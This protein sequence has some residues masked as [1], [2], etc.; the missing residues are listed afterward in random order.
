ML[1]LLPTIL[2]EESVEGNYQF[3]ED[4]LR[5]IR[6][7]ADEFEKF[8]EQKKSMLV[9]LDGP[10]GVGKSFIVKFL[11][12]MIGEEHIQICAPTNKACHVLRSSFES[13]GNTITC[14]RYFNGTNIYDTDG[15]QLWKFTLPPKTKQ[16]TIIIIDETSMIERKVYDQFVKLMDSRKIFLITLGDVCQLP[17]VDES[18]MI[19]KFYEKYSINFTLTQNIRNTNVDYNEMLGKIREFIISKRYD[20]KSY[21]IVRMLKKYIQ[22][23]SIQYGKFDLSCIPEEVIDRYIEDI[24]VHHKKICLLAYRTNDGKRNTVNELNMMIRKKLYPRSTNRYEVGEKILFTSYFVKDV[25]Y[26]ILEDNSR[27]TEQQRYYTSDADEIIKVSLGKEKF[28]DREFIIYRLYLKSFTRLNDPNVVYNNKLFICMIHHSE[29]KNFNQYSKT[30]RDG[31][32]QEIKELR[33][34]CLLKH[35]NSTECEHKLRVNVLW[36]QYYQNRE[37]VYCPIDYAYAI[38]IHKSQGSTFE[39]VYICLSDFVWLTYS[40]NS[41]QLELF[42]KLLYVGLSR[43]SHTSILF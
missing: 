33:D 22:V 13:R 11:L 6:V 21:D 39:K 24:S 31:I 12:E 30:I 42:L 25:G 5:G 17:P 9:Q 10:G 15:N 28:Y 14:H 20:M 34:Q 26:R 2:R 16:K 29:E 1:Y 23:T 40:K 8:L 3:S 32:R 36:D 38:S 19:C 18:E 41:K 35:C 43:A 7:I 4:Q 37:K 27:V